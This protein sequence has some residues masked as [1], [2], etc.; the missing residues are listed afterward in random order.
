[1]C[2]LLLVVDDS[3]QKLLPLVS[4]RRQNKRGQLF[5]LSKGERLHGFGVAWLTG[6]A[7]G[8]VVML[9]ESWTKFGDPATG[10]AAT[11]SGGTDRGAKNCG[12]E[13]AR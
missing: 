12:G 10:L 8:A 9:G 1:M 7:A 6:R 13:G 11:C 5:G 2:R 3:E 4:A